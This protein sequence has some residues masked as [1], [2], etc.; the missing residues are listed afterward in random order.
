MYVR[1]AFIFFILALVLAAN[2]FAQ[3]SSCW[4]SLRSTQGFVGVNFGLAGD[5]PAA[6]DYDGDGKVDVSVY[7]AGVWY[8]MNSSNGQV[9]TVS[10]GLAADKPVP[11]AFIE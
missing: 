2:A 4:Y 7:R 8:R 3:S 6:A 1:K 5:V 11:A 9:Q 10:F